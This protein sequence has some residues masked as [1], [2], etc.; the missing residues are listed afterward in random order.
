M[1]TSEALVD[2]GNSLQPSANLNDKQVKQ[3]K[4]SDWFRETVESSQSKI[5]N[6]QSKVSNG[7]PAAPGS[8][9]AVQ[10]LQ[11]EVDRS[12]RQSEL[13]LSQ[14]EV[15]QNVHSFATIAVLAF[16]VAIKLEHAR[17]EN[18]KRVLAVRISMNE[19]FAVMLLMK[20]IPVDKKDR[21]GK[22]IQAHL[23]GHINTIAEDIKG[24]SAMCD[25]FQ[26]KQTIVKSFRSPE[27]DGNFKFFITLFKAH[28]ENIYREIM[29]YMDINMK[30]K[31]DTLTDI[32]RSFQ[33][34]D[35]S[36]PL[37]LLLEQ[38]RS[39]EECES[40]RFVESRGGPKEILKNDE[41]M[42]EL[43]RRSGEP[44]SNT[45]LPKGQ[46]NLIQD[47]KREIQKTVADLISKNREPFFAKFDALLEQ[48]RDNVDTSVLKESDW[49]IGRLVDDPHERIIDP[50]LSQIWKDM[51]WKS[52]VKAR[53]MAM[54]LREYYSERRKDIQSRDRQLMESISAIVHSTDDSE[55]HQV[56]EIKDIMDSTDHMKGKP[57][58]SYTKDD[59]ALDYITIPRIQTLLEALD[60]DSSTLISVA[61]ANSFTTAR[62]ADWSLA[63]WLAFWTACFPLTLKYYYN[64]IQ[65]LLYQIEDLVQQTLQVNSQSVKVFVSGPAITL[66]T[67]RLLAGVREAVNDIYDDHEVFQ[68]FEDYVESQ[69]ERMRHILQTLKYRIDAENSLRLVIGS[70]GL[71]KHIMALLYLLFVRVYQVL[72]LATTTAI[73]P[74]EVDN[75]ME[76]FEVIHKAIYSRV[77]SF[78]AVCQLQNLNLKEQLRR[79][80]NGIFYYTKF[81]EDLLES[82]YW[83]AMYGDGG[84]V[85][86]FEDVGH[87][88]PV[89]EISNP[90]FAD[91]DAIQAVPSGEL[92]HPAIDDWLDV[93]AYMESDD[94]VS[95]VL[96]LTDSLAG[97][98][99]S[100][101]GFYSYSFEYGGAFTTKYP[102]G[103]INLPV[104]E[105]D[106]YISGSGSD[107]YG[108]FS[109]KGQVNGESITFNKSYTSGQVITWRYEGRMNS[110]RNQISGEW[111][112]C[113][114]VLDDFTEHLE[115]N[116]IHGDFQLDIAPLGIHKLV[117]VDAGS[118]TSNSARERWHLAVK[119]VITLLRIK[120]GKFT[121]WPYLQ[122]RS[123][124]RRR[125]LELFPRLHEL[126]SPL[127]WRAGNPLTD[128]EME[129]FLTLISCCSRQDF[130]FYRSLSACLKRR[131]I[132][133]WG[134]VC[135]LADQTSTITDT[136]FIC[137][138]CL[139]FHPVSGVAS[140]TIDLCT[141]CIDKAVDRGEDNMHHI[142][143]HDMLQLRYCCSA[144]RES[145]SLLRAAVEIAKQLRTEDAKVS[146]PSKCYKCQSTLKRPYWYCL[147]CPD[148]KRICMTCK[149]RI[150]SI[151]SPVD[152][153]KLVRTNTHDPG[154]M[155][156]EDSPGHVMA[157]IPETH[158]GETMIHTLMMDMTSSLV[159]GDIF[160]DE[161]DGE[162]KDESS[163]NEPAGG[164]ED[165]GEVEDMLEEAN[166]STGSQDR[167]EVPESGEVGSS[168]EHNTETKQQSPGHD[169][170][171]TLLLC[172]NLGESSLKKS[173][174]KASVDEQLEDIREQ[175]RAVKSMESRIL[176]RL[177][178]IMGGSLGPAALE[179]ATA[180]PM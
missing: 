68:R 14:L 15:L 86:T 58:P 44:E 136:R 77:E 137:L 92:F 167:D 131:E 112:S 69:E 135:E 155:R 61:E 165:N 20:G 31:E 104:P 71:D 16:K 101:C 120:K 6:T 91:I 49:S 27:W 12:N 145:S 81:P 72:Q 19:M 118:V 111:G 43:I 119:S 88:M 22:S 46:T 10:R 171:H 110:E 8:V 114:T 154:G 143:S 63:K 169:Y 179:N 128:G 70:G 163:G 144:R 166:G 79:I 178:H 83:T 64:R 141:E 32:S 30:P 75:I 38:L 59:W 177:D 95:P 45:S 106:G 162:R 149:D 55:A 108:E 78:K 99:P 151:Y 42:Q 127:L 158:D 109:I 133:H 29:L 164:K 2:T 85:D 100:W 18:D 51:G 52:T 3:S 174:D 5:S 35:D 123:R 87:V 142:P 146:D 126:D 150:D 74:K 73:N 138:D 53:S 94:S 152:D 176:E 26:S 89:L 159:S 140:E 168:R 113:D 21:N 125:F 33:T 67:D 148:K 60:D 66:L 90:S 157:H 4:V 37:I 96:L 129:E 134:R 40:R 80:S 39:P 41:L 105:L 107:S 121:G 93:E 24:Y 97:S 170:R 65:I 175:L 130:R 82:T 161:E 76:S 173:L 13:L 84:H 7:Q 98:R 160:P 102:A 103:V 57:T 116:E 172:R 132:V 34:A 124:I 115:Q 122:N 1:P 54:G 48:L 36:L 62:P 117:N 25:T 23:G 147:T 180:D 11:A 50:E 9:Y 156:T 139:R 28:R 56:Q 153:L 17:R 47:I